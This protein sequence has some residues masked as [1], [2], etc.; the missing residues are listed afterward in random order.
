M[1]IN[2]NI[3]FWIAVV[4]LVILVIIILLIALVGNNT[5]FKYSYRDYLE[6]E[7]KK[8]DKITGEITT[9]KRE[10]NLK[11]RFKAIFYS[12]GLNLVILIIATLVLSFILYKCSFGNQNIEVKDA[13]VE[14]NEGKF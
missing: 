7:D 8:K 3:F 13:A 6:G 4:I 12:L 1:N 11:T 14:F 10:K 9:T 2:W 5:P